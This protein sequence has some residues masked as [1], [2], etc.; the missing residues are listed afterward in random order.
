MCQHYRRSMMVVMIE[1]EQR[2]TSLK[3]RSLATTTHI[4]ITIRSLHLR[5]YFHYHQ[6]SFTTAPTHHHYP[7]SLSFLRLLLASIDATVS[8]FWGIDRVCLLTWRPTGGEAAR[9]GRVNCVAR[10][11]GK[12]RRADE[13]DSEATGRSASPLFV[14]AMLLPCSCF[15]IA[16][17]HHHCVV[18]SLLS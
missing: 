13:G 2:I 7:W 1:G 10:C 5:V 4:T 8:V 11:Q 18:G 9:A 15:I 16:L 6:C 14:V 3:A 12:A 17:S